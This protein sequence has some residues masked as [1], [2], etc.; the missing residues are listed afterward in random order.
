MK[1]E[2]LEL[3]P[4]IIPMASAR[5]ET[6]SRFSR[7]A[8]ER[9]TAS[10][11]VPVRRANR[12]YLRALRAAELDAWEKVGKAIPRTGTAAPGTRLRLPSKAEHRSLRWEVAS[13]ALLGAASLFALLAAAR[14]GCQFLAS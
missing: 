5:P 13:Y 12:E 4:V 3:P 2:L 11:R 1:T 14:I 8:A 6:I 7:S 9:F 10:L